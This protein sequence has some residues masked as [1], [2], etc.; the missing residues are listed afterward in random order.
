MLSI[1][2]IP[3]EAPFKAAV[4]VPSYVA[5]ESDLDFSST[6]V[7]FSRTDIDFSMTEDP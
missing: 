3:S 7:D 1:P 6:D 4:S 2:S 5:E